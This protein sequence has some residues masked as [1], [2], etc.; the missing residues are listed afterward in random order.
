MDTG[1]RP[2]LIQAQL[3]MLKETWTTFRSHYYS[4]RAT[5]NPVSMQINMTALQLKYT[6]A[7]G[8]LNEIS[9]KDIDTAGLPKL[10]IPDFSSKQSDWRIF[11]ELFNKIVQKMMALHGQLTY[12]LMEI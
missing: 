2:G 12:L 1:A 4:L 10:K 8:H 11:I 9:T 7:I 3:D 6:M 5:N